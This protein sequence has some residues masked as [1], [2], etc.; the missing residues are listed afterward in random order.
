MTTKMTTKMT[1]KKQ[2]LSTDDLEI[3]ISE[4]RWYPQEELIERVIELTEDS[5]LKE[6]AD[7]IRKQEDE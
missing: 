6:W 5:V 4:L 7:E 1:D 3:L 2:E